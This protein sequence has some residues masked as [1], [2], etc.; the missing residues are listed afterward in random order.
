ML[1]VF[2]DRLELIRCAGSVAINAMV[3]LGVYKGDFSEHC[4]VSLRPK[5]LTLIDRWDYERY[6]IMQSESPQMQDYRQI[7]EGYF[8]A[9]PDSALQ[10]A[11]ENVCARFRNNPD[12]EILRLDIADAA[13]RFEN[14]SIDI[15]YLDGT[16][17]Y[18]HVLQ[19]LIRW[20]PK[21][22]PGG[23]FICNDFFESA[24]ASR[25]N[26]GVIS[27]F[28]TFSKRFR[29]YPIAL[30]AGEW[31]DM[32][33]SNEPTSQLIDAFICAI[34]DRGCN[35]VWLPNELLANYHHRLTAGDRRLV[36]AF[37]F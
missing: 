1:F 10:T 14:G 26:I 2:A 19:D 37:Q 31:S 22:A 32:Y 27:A 3:E 4:Y 12:V 35:A 6:R 15:I 5:K 30:S 20:F 23:L 29:T 21:L 36:P 16:H 11:Y 33:F 7:M 9:D 25:Q 24:L 34:H 8:G 13:E 18:E 17:T 28:V